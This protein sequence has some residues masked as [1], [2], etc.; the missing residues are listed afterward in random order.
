MPPH[1]ACR[2]KA[3]GCISRLIRTGGVALA[4]SK[5]VSGCWEGWFTKDAICSLQCHYCQKTRTGFALK[6]AERDFYDEIWFSRV[7]SFTCKTWCAWNLPRCVRQ[8][9]SH[10]IIL[11]T[12]PVHL[13]CA[14]K[15]WVGRFKS[16]TALNNYKIRKRN[17]RSCIS[18]TK[19]LLNLYALLSWVKFSSSLIWIIQSCCK[20]LSKWNDCKTGF[21]V[22][23]KPKFNA[24]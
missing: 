10:I 21:K 15:S 9:A 7:R 13:P 1:R 8:T 12:E 5:L 18:L 3:L 22:T 14:I 16:A 24:L 2:Y 19:A 4:I 23:S 11:T 6:R 20:A 17:Q